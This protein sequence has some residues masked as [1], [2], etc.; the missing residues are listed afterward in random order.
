MRSLLAVLTMV[1]FTAVGAAAD[2]ETN[3]KFFRDLAETRNYTLGRPVA[4]QFTPDGAHVIFLRAQPRNPTLRLFEFTVATGEERELLTPEKILAGGEERLTAEEKA[5]RE[6]Q[7]QSLKGFTSFQI[8]PDGTRLLVVLSGKLYMLERSTLQFR[9]LP[10]ENWIDPRFSPDSRFVSAVKNRELH[11]IELATEQIVQLTHGATEYISHGVSEF[12]AQEEMKRDEGY[13]WAPDSE[14]LLYQETDETAVETRY[15]ANSLH[16]EEKPTNFAYPRAG[17]PNAVVRLGL[18]PRAGGPTRWVNWDAQHYPYVARVNWSN[19]FAPLTILVQNRTQTEQVLLAVD[20]VTGNSHEILTERDSAWLNLD[21]ESTVPRWLKDGSRFLWT[22]EQG[23]AWH[24]ELRTAAGQLVNEVTPASFSLRS[25]VGVDEARGVVYVRGSLDSREVQLWRFS[26]S[27]GPGM[28]LTREQGHH[29]AILSRISNQLVHTFELFNGRTG[30]E[31][32]DGDGKVIAVMRSVAESLPRKPTTVLTQTHTAP[33]F[34]AAITRPQNYSHEKKYPVILYVYA[35]P[36][37][38]RVNAVLRD[39]LTDQWMA[40]QGYIVVRLDGRGTPWKGRDW[41]RIIKGNFIDVALRDQIDGLTALA[42]EYHELDLARV[43]VTGW[44]FGGYFSAMATIRRPD[45]FRAGVAGAPVVTWSNYDT[46]YTER[47]LGL[48]QENP[49][50]YRVS[51][52]T[53]YASELRRPLLLIHGLTDDNVYFQH[54]LQLADALFMAGKTY[55]LLP[56]LGT[57]MVS[58]PLVKLRQQQR[59][60]EFFNLNLKSTQ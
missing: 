22:S 51:D 4:A 5:R 38:K 10:G 20:P 21:Y 12:V 13:W 46:H 25:F 44:S 19:S 52:V 29:Q 7:R 37:A 6:R 9:A 40:D 16:P 8:S 31:I 54:T 1:A 45:F 39:Y 24:L 28:P 50:A 43:G 14:T 55:E 33:A 15:I 34:D 3:L 41:E 32:I 35:G 58:D 49:E 36:T 48:P 30:A 56:M 17:S 53:T 11:L 27:G 47:Y 59:V 23:G 60:M 26:L 18:M 57:H 42:S 2:E